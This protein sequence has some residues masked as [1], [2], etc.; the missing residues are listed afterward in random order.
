MRGLYGRLARAGL[1]AAFA[2]LLLAACSPSKGKAPDSPVLAVVNG[3]PITA[4]QFKD[5]AE[6]SNLGFSNLSG[7]EPRAG[8]AKVDLLGQMIE[9]VMYLQEAGRL[10]ISASDAEVEERLRKVMADYPGGSFAD[11]LKRDGIDMGR[12]KGD[13]KN[14]LTVE[15]LIRSQVYSK[16]GVDEKRVKEYYASHKDEFRTSLR[17][18]ARQIV[19]DNKADAEA[20]LKE[21]KKGAD[22]KRLA[23]KRSLSPD[24]DMGGDLGYFS[25]GDMPPEFEAVVFKMKPGE[26]SRVVKSPYGYHIFRLEDVQKAKSPTFA[27]VEPEVRRRLLMQV[28]E[29]AFNSWREDLKGKTSI[30]VNFDVL[31]GI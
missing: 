21:L 19:L 8:D 16:T 2:A 4:A 10:N 22:F 23:E 18:R 20:V 29:E 14:R 5:K 13:L 1:A 25:K 24:S 11:T 28:G 12:Y 6:L 15:K 7:G 31:G 17:V 26:T 27:E 9:E 3:V 30:K